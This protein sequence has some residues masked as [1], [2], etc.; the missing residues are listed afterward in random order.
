MAWGGRA[1]FLLIKYSDSSL[2]SFLLI[3]PLRMTTSISKFAPKLSAKV[4]FLSFL[5]T[6]RRHIVVGDCQEFSPFLL[7][8][9]SAFEDD[10]IGCI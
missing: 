1:G 4:V 3:L 9:M 5:Y 7:A 6:L 8:T 10:K 2:H